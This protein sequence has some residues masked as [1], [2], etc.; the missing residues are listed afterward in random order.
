MATRIIVTGRGGTGK[1]TFSAL[2]VGALEGPKL[3]I[4][5]D[6]DQCLSTLLGIDLQTEGIKTVSEAMHEIQ[7]GNAGQSMESMPLP[8]KI[9]YL[10][11]LSCL[12]EGPGFDL[13]TLGVKWT[14]GC[15]CAPNNTLRSLISELSSN[16]DFAVFDSPA[17]LE[18]INRR[19]VSRADDVF[20]ITD[21]SAKGLRNT[22]RFAE[23]ANGIDFSYKNLYIVANYRFSAELTESLTD[24]E[25]ARYLGKIEPDS[26]VES[27]DWSGRSLLDLP[28]QSPACQS[29]RKVLEKAGYKTIDRKLT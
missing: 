18:H 7:T 9:E 6:P 11:Q 22:R 23:I 27:F 28:Q 14:R 20:A 13:L 16:Y 15:Y 17:G 3:V 12:H 29:V 24:T 8:E 19:V 21:P 26:Q 4:D 5:A 1:S 10:L 25:H 2:C